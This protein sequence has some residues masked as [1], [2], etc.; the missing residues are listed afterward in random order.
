MLSLLLLLLDISSSQTSMMLQQEQ[1]Q[2]G[3]QA[4]SCFSRIC[5]TLQLS[6]AA[7]SL[8]D[9]SWLCLLLEQPA[10]SCS[11]GKSRAIRLLSESSLVPRL[12]LC[13][14]RLCLCIN[15]CQ[16]LATGN[17]QKPCKELPSGGLWFII[18][19]LLSAHV[20]AKKYI[21]DA[22]KTTSGRIILSSESSQSQFYRLLIFIS[23]LIT[24]QGGFFNYPPPLKS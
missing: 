5:F 16:L 8:H 7:L 9:G 23:C 12:V 20:L 6:R 14:H 22:N 15:Q 13:M 1:Q 24:I 4:M 18:G 3:L 10:P 2:Q 17:H 11:L 21:K 19:R